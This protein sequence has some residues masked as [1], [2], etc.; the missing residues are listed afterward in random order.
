MS[1]NHLNTFDLTR[2]EVLSKTGYSTRQIARQLNRPHS[3]I[4]RE[5]K[6][7]TQQMYQAEL[8]DDLARKRHLVCHRSKKK[9][10]A[11]I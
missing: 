3:T 10:E 11:V 9:S 7:N 6:W 2:I 8:L 5:L 4:A 1:Y